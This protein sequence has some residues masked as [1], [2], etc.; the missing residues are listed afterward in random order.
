[1]F[2]VTLTLIC[3]TRQIYIKEYSINFGNTAPV[4]WYD[5][6]KHYLLVTVRVALCSICHLEVPESN[7]CSSSCQHT[8][9]VLQGQTHIW[10]A[11]A[12]RILDEASPV[13][14][15]FALGSGRRPFWSSQDGIWPQ[16]M[17]SLSLLHT[18]FR[19][20]GFSSHKCRWTGTELSRV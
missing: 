5:C 13:P 12:F 17:N 9:L 10:A 1:M 4:L 19:T 16:Y 6:V 14:C 7:A 15:R 2:S 8:L 11:A 20:D 3:E 18:W